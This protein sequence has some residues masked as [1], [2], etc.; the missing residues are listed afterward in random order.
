MFQA[1]YKEQLKKQTGRLKRKQPTIA[2]RISERAYELLSSQKGNQLP[3]K[4][5]I[6]RIEKTEEVKRPSIYAALSRA[7]FIEKLCKAGSNTVLCKLK[8]TTEQDFPQIS[9]IHNPNR[10]NEAVRAISRLTIDEVDVGLFL[11]GRLF[12]T[13]LRDYVKKVERLNVLPVE[14]GNYR[15]LNNMIAW[16]KTNQIIIDESVL[17]IL[18]T[19]RNDRAHGAPPSAEERTIMLQNSDFIAR[20]YLD[21]IVFFERKFYDLDKPQP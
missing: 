5:L 17:H 21:Y 13:T 11:L 19:V 4:E 8:G 6:A 7:P 16:V 20:S 14:P 12:E 2:Q 1:D 18:R 3:L 9:Y 15:N 10:K